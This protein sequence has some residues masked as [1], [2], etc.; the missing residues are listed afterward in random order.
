MMATRMNAPWARSMF[1]AAI[2]IP[3]LSLPV[4]GQGFVEPNRSTLQPTTQRF[5]EPRFQS[6]PIQSAS[7]EAVAQSLKGFLSQEQLGQFEVVGDRQGNRI[8]VRGSEP[9]LQA[10][11]QY[12]RTVD[13]PAAVTAQPYAQTQSTVRGYPIQN[14][15]QLQIRLKQLRQQFANRKDIRIAADG[16]TRQLIIHAPVSVHNQ[17]ATILRSPIPAS[18]NP[19]PATPN[20]AAP[21]QFPAAPGNPAPQVNQPAVPPVPPQTL[22]QA[23]Q[24][25]QLRNIDW[26]GLLRGMRGLARQCCPPLEVYQRGEQFTHPVLYLSL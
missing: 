18:T 25:V 7:A 4:F 11:R 13:R 17:I 6:I 16:R 2:L 24:R 19:L 22:A 15:S 9:L 3:S 5:A 14:E 21:V 1:T 10:A 12:V 23:T 20:G 8:L 26:R